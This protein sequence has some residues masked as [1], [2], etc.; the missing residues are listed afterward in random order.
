[1]SGRIWRKFKFGSASIFLKL[2]ITFIVITIPMFGLS[3]TLNELG[4]QEVQKQLSNTMTSQIHYY[5]LSLEKEIQQI[6]KTQQEMINDEDLQ[7]LYG[8]AEIMS[9]YQKAKSIDNLSNKLK[10]FKGSSSYIQ[11]INLYIPTLTDMITTSNASL[12]PTTEEEMVEISKAIYSEGFPLIYWKDRLYVHL[13]FPNYAGPDET[14]DALFMM[15]VEL[16]IDALR[17]ELSTFH[18]AGETVLFSDTWAIGSSKDLQLFNE[19]GKQLDVEQAAPKG[20]GTVSVGSKRYAVTYE[21]SLSLDATLLF[22]LAEDTM[23]GTLKSYRTWFWLLLGCSLIIVIL[24]SYGI[25]MLIHRPLR[26]LVKLFKNVEAGN[27]NLSTTHKHQDEFGYLFR[28]FNKMVQNLKVLIDELYVQKISLQHAELKQLQAQINPHFL[29]NSFFILHRLIKNYE[30]D[31][32]QLVSKHFGEYFHYITRNA[33]D[34]V[35]FEAEV[36]HIRSYIEIQNVRF[37]N[38]IEVVFDALPEAF[39]G[40]MVPRLILQ[41]VIENA[42]QHGLGEKVR[43]GCLHIHFHTQEGQL[44]MTVEDNGPG[45]TG[46]EA[47]QLQRKLNREEPGGESTG[48]INV[49]RRLQLKYGMAG[50]ITLAPSSLGGLLVQIH[51]PIGKGE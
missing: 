18:Q 44:C 10:S 35:A 32:A 23:L 19:I 40:V 26:T 30:N 33:Q 47:E 15:N 51:I 29:Y 9:E 4:K 27:F 46:D 1:M 12:E 16:S 14:K 50:G 20:P 45:L 3:L 21:K 6:I 5:F 37:S 28:Q 11:N 22:Y 36:K 17:S 25:Y 39:Q 8:M 48:L 38:R 42:Y 43:A 31:T 7:K 34:E 2:I 49:H 24:F 13:T 41:P